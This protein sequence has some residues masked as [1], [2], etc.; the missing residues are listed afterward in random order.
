LRPELFPDPAGGAY[1]TPPDI[2]AEFKGSAWQQRR[3]G[4]VDRQEGRGGE[5]KNGET[6]GGMERKG[7]T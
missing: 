6:G 1:N 5:E 3:K 4:K 7:R 2:L